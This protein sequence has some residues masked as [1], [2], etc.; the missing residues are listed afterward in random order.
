M[1]INDRFDQA[2]DAFERIHQFI[3]VF[4]LPNPQLD[5][6]VLAIDQEFCSLFERGEIDTGR[7][8]LALNSIDAQ[9]FVHD[10][11]YESLPLASYNQ[12]TDTIIDF[13]DALGEV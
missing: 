4:L 6:A 8:Y 10:S 7:V 2:I 5:N 1:N 9:V 11:Q 13:L 12:W 3:N